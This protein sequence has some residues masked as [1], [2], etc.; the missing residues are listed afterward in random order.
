MTFTWI[1]GKD[2]DWLGLQ[3]G[4]TNQV[5]ALD[6]YRKSHAPEHMWCLSGVH[7]IENLKMAGFRA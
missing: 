3:D 2:A 4:H 1:L 7:L 6:K 5:A